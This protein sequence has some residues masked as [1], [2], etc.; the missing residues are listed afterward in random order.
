MGPTSVHG[1]LPEFTFQPTSLLL[2]GSN[3]ALLN[4]V[5]FAV[6][7]RSHPGFWWT[8]VRLREERLDPLDPLARHV[9]PED[10]LGVIA[11]TVLQR[12]PDRSAT[13]AT[14]IRPD[15]PP[16]SLQRVMEFLRLPKHTQELISSRPATK[17][18]AQVALS[19]CH[20]LAAIFPAGS[21][22]PTVRAILASGVSLALTWADALPASAQH[23][24][25]VLGVEGSGPANWQQATL[26]CEIGNS[27]GLA[28][29]GQRFKLGELRPIAEVLGPMGL[30][31]P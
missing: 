23:F 2:H 15:E 29:A 26:H 12:E 5:M 19:N 22:E 25:F 4:W 17:R 8:D 7:D 28:R 31:A 30:A 6:L 3:R 1:L 21:V 20:R 24:D 11:P 14:M 27:S 10:H 18:P 13:L 16:P 9:I